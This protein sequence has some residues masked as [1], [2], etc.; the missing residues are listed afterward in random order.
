MPTDF[1]ATS[2]DNFGDS[3]YDAVVYWHQ[4]QSRGVGDSIPRMV[5][6]VNKWVGLS[7]WKQIPIFVQVLSVA[8]NNVRGEYWAA[9]SW[10]AYADIGEDTV[11][12]RTKNI[13]QRVRM[14][15]REMMVISGRVRMHLFKCRT[16]CHFLLTQGFV[17]R[18]WTLKYAAV[19][20]CL[21]L[22]GCVTWS[23]TTE[24]RRLEMCASNM[25][26][27]TFGSKRDEAN[28]RL[29][30]VV[31]RGASWFVLVTAVGGACRV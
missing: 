22:W 18:T 13:G 16:V 4:I 17:L 15:V 10:P 31:Q 29:Y 1:C 23:V 9:R 21:L 27:N 24:H 19:W 14:S 25:R 8:V 26:R 12:A 6:L 20:S 28:R 7:H 11:Q 2:P 3:V 5:R 30:T